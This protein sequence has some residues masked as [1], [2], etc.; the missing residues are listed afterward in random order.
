MRNEFA[1]KTLKRI[2]KIQD[3]KEKLQELGVELNE[4]ED[5][6]NLL[7]ESIAI[8]FSKDEKTF[9]E[10]IGYI[11]KFLYLNKFF[12]GGKGTVSELTT[13]EEFVNWLDKEYPQ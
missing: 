12:S 13:S 9:E 1:I 10:V 6:V 7:E 2:K 11:H 5:G 3:T 4:Y 8:M